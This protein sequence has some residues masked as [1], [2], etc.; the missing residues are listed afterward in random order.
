MIAECYAD[1]NLVKKFYNIIKVEK[2]IKYN[3]YIFHQ[4]IYHHTIIWTVRFTEVNKVILI[5]EKDRSKR[6][7]IK[8]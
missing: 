5:D 6:K 2:D 8:V 7:E 3:Y 1:E 4:K